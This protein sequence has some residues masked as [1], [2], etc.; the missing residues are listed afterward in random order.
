M[1]PQVQPQTQFHT[2]HQLDKPVTI[3]FTITAH[4][5]LQTPEMTPHASDAEN[6]AT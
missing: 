5:M 6:K 4:E 1:T 3:V 2:E